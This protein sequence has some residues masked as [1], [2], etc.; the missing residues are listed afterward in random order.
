M[1]ES[2]YP[3]LGKITPQ[4]PPPHSPERIVLIRPCCIGDVIMATA[5]LKALRRGYP[6]A[7]ITFAVGTWSKR[8]IEHHDLLDEVLD[9]GPSAN[10]ART[11]TGLRQTAQVL[12]QGNFDLAVS[13]VRS[14]LMSMAVM[15]SGIP[16]RVGLDSAGRGFGYTVRVPIDPNK[17][18]HE[19]GIYLQ[20]VQALGMDTTYCYANVPVYPQDETAAKMMLQ[21]QGVTGKN[22]IVINPTGGNN[23]GATMP[24]KR[25]PLQH[26]AA[27]ADHLT[28]RFNQPIVLIGGPA[29][30]TIVETVANHMTHP[31]ISF[32]GT[33]TFPQIAALAKNATGYIGND[34]GLTHLA[35]AAGARTVMILGPSDPAR[36]APFTPDA[37]TIWKPSKLKSGGVSAG[38]TDHWHWER[39]G[40]SLDE[41]IFQTETFLRASM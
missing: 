27:L 18:Q 4:R 12:R 5:A 10:P 17:T 11:F 32:V 2:L 1:I 14:P 15:L 9:L 26:M 35:A 30:Q 29:D 8:A 16:H 20:T 19:A 41:V 21:S 23:P 3:L 22:Y 7:H 28:T 24:A 34:T 6:Q 38:I 13:L 36:Y 37:I 39:D 31:A 40:V 33:L 25:Y